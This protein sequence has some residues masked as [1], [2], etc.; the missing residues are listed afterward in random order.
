MLND[1]G[2]DKWTPIRFLIL[3]L[4]QFQRRGYMVRAMIKPLKLA[5]TH[6]LKSR[7]PILVEQLGVDA[8]ASFDFRA[9]LHSVELFEREAG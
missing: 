2:N 3:K 5:I 9:R 6:T 1:K 7:D 4:P 8:A